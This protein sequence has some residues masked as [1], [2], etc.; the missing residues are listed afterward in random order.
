MVCKKQKQPQKSLA[1]SAA[2]GLSV[3]SEA[4]GSPASDSLQPPPA[5]PHSS[6][7]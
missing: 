6:F 5:L 7:G 4:L 2:Q 1:L 3:S